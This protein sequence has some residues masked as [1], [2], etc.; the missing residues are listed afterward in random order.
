M[1]NYADKDFRYIC[2]RIFLHHPPP[3]LIKDDEEG[4]GETRYS[5]V[6]EISDKEPEVNQYVCILMLA[7]CIGL[8]AGT[9]EW[10]RASV[11]MPFFI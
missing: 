7:I 9:A 2:S 1:L 6:S 4:S 10:V 5:P 8:M 3:G 11:Y